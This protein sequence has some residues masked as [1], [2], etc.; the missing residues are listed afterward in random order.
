MEG[1]DR[2]VLFLRQAIERVATGDEAAQARLQRAWSDHVQLLWEQKYLPDDL[3]E[4]FKQ[5]WRSYT[6]QTDD[7]KT[8]QL[9]DLSE[10]QRAAAIRELIALTMDA[11]KRHA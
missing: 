8:T 1:L 4:R 6:A 7:P 2:A 5:L 3:N 11:A 9:R 10:D